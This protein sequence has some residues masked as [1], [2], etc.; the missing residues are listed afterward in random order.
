MYIGEFHDCG[1]R[2]S[3]S[4][5]CMTDSELE[6]RRR[7]RSTV[8]E[9]ELVPWNREKLLA[10][11]DFQKIGLILGG[12][13]CRGSRLTTRN[14]DGRGARTRGKSRDTKVWIPALARACAN[15]RLITSLTLFIT[16]G[17]ASFAPGSFSHSHRDTIAHSRGMKS[18]LLGS[19]TS[20]FSLSLF[21]YLSISIQCRQLA[22]AIDC[23][24]RRN[25][26]R[27]YRN[28]LAPMRCW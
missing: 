18:T 6:N 24:T 11:L 9:I 23:I 26:A 27:K 21:L 1:N 25:F 12:Q 15:P 13:P 4:L 5:I 2:S 8:T 14:R 28:S 3:R 19:F 20:L 7:R 17:R 22:V 10:F 16:A